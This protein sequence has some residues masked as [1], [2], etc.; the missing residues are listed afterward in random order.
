M[1]VMRTVVMVLTASVVT[2]DMARLVMVV[3]TDC[4]G[5][6][7]E[8]A[9]QKGR[10]IFIRAAGSA[11]VKLNPGLSQ[12]GAGAAANAA[13]DEDMDS[14]LL[15]KTSQSAVAAA[16]GV[17][18]LGGENLISYYLIDLKLLAMPEVLKDLSALIGDRNVHVNASYFLTNAYIVHLF[19]A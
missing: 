4:I 13:A 17:N 3:G 2:A 9:G 5:V 10:H 6:V 12:R 18:D 7:A 16:V 14:V 19:P 1:L 8:S 11:G 15:K